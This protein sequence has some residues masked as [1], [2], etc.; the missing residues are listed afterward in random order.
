ML[1][2]PTN[3]A[4]SWFE[5]NQGSDFSQLNAEIPHSNTRKR[6]SK[7]NSP[8]YNCGNWSLPGIS[9]LCFSTTFP[10]QFGIGVVGA[11]G[12]GA[13]AKIAG[14][15]EYTLLAGGDLNAHPSPPPQPLNVQKSR[16]VS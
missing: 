14:N 13:I 7:L 6:L 3:A 5:E 16:E 1:V 2:R 4:D 10:H 8:S 11:D 15:L 12:V 9:D